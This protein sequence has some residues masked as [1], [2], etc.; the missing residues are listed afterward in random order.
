M[1]VCDLKYSI[2]CRFTQKSALTTLKNYVKEQPIDIN[3]LGLLGKQLKLTDAV[4]TCQE[5]QVTDD[6][7]T[8]TSFTDASSNPFKS[9]EVIV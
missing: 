1:E 7:S 5:P 6:N 8:K 9:L 2:P 3:I 4:M